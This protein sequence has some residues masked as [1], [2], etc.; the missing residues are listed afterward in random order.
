MEFGNRS[1][2]R[3]RWLQLGVLLALPAIAPFP[4]FAAEEGNTPP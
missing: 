2:K 4:A 3:L 1:K